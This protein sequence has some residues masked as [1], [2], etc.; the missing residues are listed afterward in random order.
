[1]K[2]CSHIFL[3]KRNLPL[4]MNECESSIVEKIFFHVIW[5]INSVYSKEYSITQIPPSY[6]IWEPIN[7]VISIDFPS[8]SFSVEK[9]K[10]IDQHF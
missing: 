4:G 3:K 2:F 9:K 1:M 8:L 10:Y 7:F 6:Q 5:S